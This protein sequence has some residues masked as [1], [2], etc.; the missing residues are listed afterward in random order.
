MLSGVYASSPA[1]IAG[2]KPGD[3]ITHF[4]G[5]LIED[6]NKSLSYVTDLTPGS[7]LSITYRRS[8][9]TSIVTAILGT[10]PTAQ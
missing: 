8:G 4:D 3:L 6:W 1:D 5:N 7:E 2:L 9:T 10:R